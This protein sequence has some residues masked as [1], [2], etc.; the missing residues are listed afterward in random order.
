LPNLT[1]THRAKSIAMACVCGF[2][3]D[4]A[5]TTISTRPEIW[6]RQS[7]EAAGNLQQSVQIGGNLEPQLPVIRNKGVNAVSHVSY[8]Q[9]RI[10]FSAEQP[11][12]IHCK[13]NEQFCVKVANEQQ[14]VLCDKLQ[15]RMSPH[16]KIAKMVKNF[17]S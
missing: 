12:Q 9:D 3:A 11:Q 13:F 7:H 5:L 8:A 15:Q 6:K 2:P 1:C 17:L 16:S 10:L 14:E 4:D